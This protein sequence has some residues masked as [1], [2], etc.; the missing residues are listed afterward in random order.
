VLGL[1]EVQSEGLDREKE[2]KEVKK[3]GKSRR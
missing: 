3:G 1:N 2:G